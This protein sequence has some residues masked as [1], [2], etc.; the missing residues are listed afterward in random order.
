MGVRDAARSVKDWTSERQPW[1]KVKTGA[2]HVGAGMVGLAVRSRE[3]ISAEA[4]N[5]FRFLVFLL[6]ALVIHLYI[7]LGTTNIFSLERIVGHVLAAFLLC[8]LLL[9]IRLRERAEELF[10][11]FVIALFLPVVLMW[12]SKA[13]SW[14]GITIASTPLAY[15][16]N[17][18]LVP[19]W[20]YYAIFQNHVD[21][22]WRGHSLKNFLGTLIWLFWLVLILISLVQHLGS[23]E[24]KFTYDLPEEYKEQAKEQVK[25]LPLLLKQVGSVFTTK[26]GALFEKPIRYAVGDDYYLGMVEKSKEEKIGVYLENLRA[27]APQFFED[28][29]VSVWG[30]LKARTLRPDKLIH[31]T[32]E[33][34]AVPVSPVP[35]LQNRIIGDANLA[36]QTTL[37][38][39]AEVAH[40][41]HVDLS[42]EF[43]PGLL[44]RGSRR[45]SF[46][47]T[48][49][50]ST[51][52]YVK[53]YFMDQERLRALIRQNVNPLAQ[54]GITETIPVAIY[55]DGPIGIGMETSR[56]EHGALVPVTPDHAFRFGITIENKW[57]GKIHSLRNVSFK[58]PVGMRVMPDSCDFNVEEVPCSADQVLC[59]V[60]AGVSQ[61]SMVYGVSQSSR[62]DL[63]GTVLKRGL[64]VV[65]RL[66]A[67]GERRFV[68]FTCRVGFDNI[69]AVLGNV[70]LATHYFKT[71]IEYKYVLDK[72]VT[73]ILKPVKDFLQPGVPFTAPG[74]GPEVPLELYTVPA[75][76]E[77]ML[78][79]IWATYED[80]VTEANQETGVPKGLIMAL[81]AT[82]SGGDPLKISNTGAAGLGQ[83]TYKTK[84]F[85]TIRICCEQEA[86]EAAPRYCTNERRRCGNDV[87]CAAGGYQCSPD[88]TSPLYDD[89]FNARNSILSIADRLA[90][91]IKSYA[92]YAARIE[93][94]LASYNAGGRPVKNAITQTGSDNPSW[95]AV[96]AHITPALLQSSGYSAD[97]W[98]WSVLQDKAKNIPKYV[99]K[100]M[101]LSEKAEALAEEEMV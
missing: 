52:S 35:G 95:G 21:P 77:E 60:P 19:V 75:S 4:I 64:D 46:N 8:P 56:T 100:I 6:V 17:L 47:T 30:I 38:H 13:L 81:I 99:N 5:P 34:V 57:E 73:V 39:V 14:A 32:T 70:P 28:E 2:R 94:A 65:N 54:Q 50:F 15:L 67:S 29:P 88:Q 96:A 1:E 62:R 74:I 71:A 12:L 27:A 25:Q 66:F 78:R 97:R 7:E 16:T 40:F 82:E 98:E 87:W 37:Q 36:D 9:G 26:V 83:F 59:V 91:D 53:A 43:P 85:T 90:T 101:A 63:S 18:F 55:T 42:C 92:R 84:F 49:D 20:I 86:G 58:L 31:V 80:E 89:R 68:S 72:S 3:Y 93:F 61:P 41:E 33:C 22:L 51:D 44:G 23:L 79:K 24:D 11:V 76:D 45:I 10:T 69:E 48:F